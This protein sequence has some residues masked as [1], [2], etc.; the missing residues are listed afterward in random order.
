MKV[1][2]IGRVAAGKGLFDGQTIKTRNLYELLKTMDGIEEVMLVDT[3]EYKKHIGSVFLKTV[4]AM[5]KCD[6]IVLSVS[7]NGRKIFFPLLYYL[8]KIFKK[9]I[10]HSLIGGRLAIHV[11]QNPSW[12]KYVNSFK[13]NWVECKEIQRDLAKIGVTNGVYLPNFKNISVVKVNEITP[14]YGDTY[15]FCIFSR[16]QKKKGIE[17]AVYAIKAVNRKISAKKASLDI[18]GPIDEEYKAE[19]QKLV[20]EHSEY[21]SYLGCV[22]AD[23]S[24]EA[25]KGYY[26]LIF[27]TRYFNEGVPGTIID[28]LA[29]GMPVISRRWHYCDEMIENGVTGYIYEFEKPEK[30]EECILN[31]MLEEGNNLEMKKACIRK[32]EEYLPEKAQQIILESF[33]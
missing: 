5:K 2:L 3:Y 29:A 4:Q 20:N 9:E 1:A 15:K 14:Y 12:I 22:E 7:I 32:A 11:R 17:D 6:K 18:Y 13:V 8:N 24:V 16:V 28:A 30:L 10:Y 26:A 27:P 33:R 23:K 25:I 21:V 31:A 19:F